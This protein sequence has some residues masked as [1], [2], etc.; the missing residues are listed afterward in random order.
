MGPLDNITCLLVFYS[1]IQSCILRSWNL[2]YI[3]PDEQEEKRI[4]MRS[5]SRLF[6]KQPSDTNLGSLAKILE[7]HGNAW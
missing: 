1:S 7:K 2:R 3:I 4:T 6:Y 5:G